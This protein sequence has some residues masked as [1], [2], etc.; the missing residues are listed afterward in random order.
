MSSR[1]Y[2]LAEIQSLITSLG[3]DA[4]GYT[5]DLA[6]TQALSRLAGV[7]SS[8]LTVPDLDFLKDLLRDILMQGDGIDLRG[9][10]CLLDTQRKIVDSK[11]L[12]VW[13]LYAM[14]EW[15]QIH[16]KFE[17]TGTFKISI[18]NVGLVEPIALNERLQPH[19][20]IDYTFPL[21]EM[22][23]VFSCN[24][25]EH[26]ATL[27]LHKNV[28]ATL[29]RESHGHSSIGW[30]NFSGAVWNAAFYEFPNKNFEALGGWITQRLKEKQKEFIE[31]PKSLL[32]PSF[33]GTLYKTLFG[34]ETFYAGYRVFID[35]Q[36]REKINNG[37][38]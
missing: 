12:N 25:M 23:T 3:G 7:N 35:D 2:R 11:R 17:K 6:K 33:N 5:K 10:G 1:E 13:R 9:I 22:N 30:F 29:N 20:K 36:L 24:K 37:L 19:E 27:E 34:G 18:P 8:K 14:A 16:E 38:A 31:L 26:L 21:S 32:I 28:N 4:P 15:A